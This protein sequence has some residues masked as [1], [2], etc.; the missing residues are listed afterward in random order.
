MGADGQGDAITGDVDSSHAAVVGKG[1]TQQVVNVNTARNAEELGERV[2]RLEERLE[3][4]DMPQNNDTSPYAL[5]RL[6][7]KVDR[8]LEQQ[9]TMLSEQSDMRRRL[10]AVEGLAQGLEKKSPMLDRVMVTL[11]ALAMLAMLAFNVMV[12]R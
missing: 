4:A 1:I 9:N 2:A 8:I 7:S 6:E 5:I 10:S 11:L 12:L 3:A